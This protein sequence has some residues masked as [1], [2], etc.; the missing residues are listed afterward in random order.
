[1]RST[2]TRMPFGAS[3]CFA[4][5]YPRFGCPG[6]G[7]AQGGEHRADLVLGGEGAGGV[8]AAAEA[9]DHRVVSCSVLAVRVPAGVLR[10]RELF[11]RRGVARH[12]NITDALLEHLLSDPDPQVADD[13]AAN[14]ALRPTQMYRILTAAGL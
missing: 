12:P 5:P 1:M 10:M 11:L 7:V 4:A 8:S 2:E 14:P 3:S 13:A 6:L 9:T